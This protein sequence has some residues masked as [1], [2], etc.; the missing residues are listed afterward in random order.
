LIKEG[1]PNYPMFG[2]I[3]SKS[4][5]SWGKKPKLGVALASPHV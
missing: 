1:E 4:W 5:V 2:A 3:V